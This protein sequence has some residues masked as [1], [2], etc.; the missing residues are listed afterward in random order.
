MDICMNNNDTLAQ[1]DEQH[2]EKFENIKNEYHELLDQGEEIPTWLRDRFFTLSVFKAVRENDC[3][4]LRQHL[5]R[6][7]K[8]T[9][10]DFQQAV[11]RDHFDVFCILIE[12]AHQYSFDEVLVG[13]HAA[14]G[15]GQKIYVDF[16]L[17]FYLQANQP[18]N[19]SECLLAAGKGQ[20]FDIVDQL[21]PYAFQE[22]TVYCL[23][24]ALMDENYELARMIYPHSDIAGVVHRLEHLGD[25]RNAPQGL[26]WID[27]QQ[28]SLKLKHSVEHIVSEGQQRLR[29]L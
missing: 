28:M 7:N 5:M 21:I 23:L 17:P 12:R 2:N 26:Q 20:H 8:I 19:L 29:K 16:A 27:S 25:Q 13:L 4:A 14:C 6:V 24:S 1:F 22:K 9:H 18:K 10:F 11:L 15:A 3:E